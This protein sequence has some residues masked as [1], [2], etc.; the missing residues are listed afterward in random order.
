MVTFPRA[1]INIGLR[2][3]EKRQDG[4]HNI[5]TL[6]FPI[7]LCDALEFVESEN[8]N[9]G[10]I[11]TV[12]GL[13]T[14]GNPDDNLVMKAVRRLRETF[15]F[16]YLKM[17]LH[18]AIPAGAGLGGG[19][20]DAAFILKGINRCYGLKLDNNQLR[21]IS[22]ELGS[23]CPFFI[24]SVPAF[25][26]GRGE[27]LDSCNKQL[28]LNYYMVLLNPGININTREAY[29]NCRPAIPPQS[30]SWIIQNNAPGKCK[31]LIINDFEDYAFERFPLIRNLKEELY[32][33]G[34]I[35]S[36]MSGSG[37]SVYAIF[38]NRHPIP[39]KLR[40][41]VIWQGYLQEPIPAR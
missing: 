12:T 39:E 28:L 37:S 9:K 4:F 22:L 41:Y 34:A 18:K 29:Q 40:G 23:D 20:S 17:H 3:T 26:S 1:K 7:P 2:I 24:D 30:L 10:D 38:R 32:R 11:L 15:S 21:S 33:S 36:L 16:P 5:E 35:F 8:Q 25:A 19:S 13:E 31:E 14:G 27:I 6:F